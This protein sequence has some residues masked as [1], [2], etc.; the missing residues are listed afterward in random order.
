MLFAVQPG[1]LQ[2]AADLLLALEQGGVFFAQSAPVLPGEEAQPIHQPL[3]NPGCRSVGARQGELDV[4]QGLPGEL[5]QRLGLEFFR[6][7]TFTQIRQQTARL[8]GVQPMAQEQQCFGGGF[9]QG[10]EGKQQIQ[11]SLA[12]LLIT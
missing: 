6:Q 8:L 4:Q 7:S 10:L 12:S 11:S 5:I 2:G 1:Q 9:G 3:A